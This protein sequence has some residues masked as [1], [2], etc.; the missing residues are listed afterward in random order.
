MLLNELCIETCDDCFTQMVHISAIGTAQVDLKP[1][2]IQ[3]QQLSTVNCHGSSLMA[4]G[5]VDRFWPF[6]GC[7]VSLLGTSDAEILVTACPLEP[8]Y[9]IFKLNQVQLHRVSTC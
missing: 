4:M 9:L 6:V 1:A 8:V 3:E 7:L 2:S 5:R